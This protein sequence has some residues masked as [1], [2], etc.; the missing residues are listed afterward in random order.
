M[1]Q[2]DGKSD[3]KKIMCRGV[4]YPRQVSD[5]QALGYDIKFIW[6]MLEE[7]ILESMTIPHISYRRRQK[8]RICIL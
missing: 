3:V 4:L 2:D 1:G 6:K 8:N 5:L 7:W